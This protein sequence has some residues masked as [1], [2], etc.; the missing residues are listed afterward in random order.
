MIASFASNDTERIAA[1]AHVRKFAPISR[2][3]QRKLRYLAA[4]AQLR[5]LLYLPGTI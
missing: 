2:Q 5:I 3:A 1:G 4:A